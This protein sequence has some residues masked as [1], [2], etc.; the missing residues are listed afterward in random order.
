MGRNEKEDMKEKKM[1]KMKNKTIY[2]EVLIKNR[3]GNS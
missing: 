3:K 2:N 1:L